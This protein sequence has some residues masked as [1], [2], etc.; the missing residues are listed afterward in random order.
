VRVGG[1][2]LATFKTQH[3]AID[4]A[5]KQGH[6]PLVA[7]VRH[8]N[9]KKKPI[10]GGRPP[11]ELRLLAFAT[12][13]ALQRLRLQP[14]HASLIGGDR[15]SSSGGLAKSTA[16]CRASSR[17]SR[18]GPE[19]CDGAIYPNWAEKRK[20]AGWQT[21]NHPTAGQF[22][23]PG[24]PVRFGGR[25][26]EVRPAPLLGQHTNEVLRDWLGLDAGE[27]EQLGKDGVV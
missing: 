7:R 18:F 16:I 15:R 23:M 5:R 1:G 9:D 24:W 4:W 20:R 27:I 10:T 2:I 19:R 11:N 12:D 14:R 13:S 8:L 17:V 21:M 26:P 25:T 6:A 3:E 22:K